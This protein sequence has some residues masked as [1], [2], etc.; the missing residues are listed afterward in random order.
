MS[1]V[2]ACNLSKIGVC[3]GKF[4]LQ[5]GLTFINVMLYHLIIILCQ[6]PYSLTIELSNNNNNFVLY[7]VFC[8]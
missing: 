4:K 6:Q 3:R 7:E 5:Y 1:Y 8:F 2:I